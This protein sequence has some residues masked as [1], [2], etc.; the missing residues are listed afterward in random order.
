MAVSDLKNNIVASYSLDGNSSDNKNANNGTDTAITYSSGNG[1]INQGAGFN[2]STSRIDIANNTNFNFTNGT[3]D[4]PFTIDLW[5]NSSSISTNQMIIN[6][7]GNTVVTDEWQVLL[8]SGNI[9]ITLFSSSASGYMEVNTNLF[10]FSSNTWY[11]LAITYSGSGTTAGI[12]IYVNGTSQSLANT[13][14]GTYTR[15]PIGSSIVRL[16]TPSWDLTFLQYTGKLDIIRMFKNYTADSSDVAYLYN[17]G[18]GRQYPFS[19]S[20][21]LTLL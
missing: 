16:G 13:T 19:N 20:N 8:F 3:T 18:N 15:M 7:R 6:K 4:L 1:K 11:H 5:F 10:T 12:K 9:Y 17:S 21:F 14:V 2:G